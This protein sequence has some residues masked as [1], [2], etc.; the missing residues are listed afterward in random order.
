VALLLPVAVKPEKL[1]FKKRYNL[2]NYFLFSDILKFP[3]N[4]N[5]FLGFPSTLVPSSALTEH[6]T[7][8]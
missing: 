4:I 5:I 3:H 1:F 7:C 2:H 6:M 8:F